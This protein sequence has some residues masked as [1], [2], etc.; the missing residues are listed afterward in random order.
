MPSPL[1]PPLLLAAL[2]A[3]ALPARA[4]RAV[5]A[6]TEER[7]RQAVAES[8]VA[9]GAAERADAGTLAVTDAHADPT[10]G[11]TFVYLAQTLGGV[12]VDA[13]RV[14]VGLGQDGAPFHVA[15][16]LVPDIASARPQMP[17]LSAA[18]AGVAAARA[19][20]PGTAAADGADLVYVVDGGG[21]LRLAWRVL[22]PE[23]V[24]AD[25]PHRWRVDVDAATGAEIARADL[26]LREGDPGLHGPV[27]AARPD[28]L[29]DVAPLAEQSPFAP[30]A[31]AASYRV[32]ALPTESPTHAGDPAT[33]LRTLV[34]DPHDA[35][36][37]LYGWHDTNGAVGAEH[38][39]TRGNNVDAA[40]HAGTGQTAPNGGPG[41]TFSFP[42]DP[43]L[44]PAANL[45]AAVTNAFY[46]LNV[47]HDVLYR[48][49][50][51]EGAGDFQQN[52]Y[53]RG[54][55]AGDAVGVTVQEP[56]AINNGYMATPVD[57]LP[58]TLLLGRW[59]YTAPERDIAF[60]ASVVV[61]EYAH[62]LSN[63]LVGGPSAFCL[64][65]LEQPGEGWSDLV[66]MLLTMRPGDNRHTPRGI[67]AYG[68]G[69]P[70]GG[71]IRPAPYAADFAINAYTYGDTRTL[72]GP[73]RVGF[74]WA[75]AVW[76]ATW[77][78]IDAYGFSPDVYD[79]AGTAGNQ[80]ALR[81]L[82]TGLKLTPCA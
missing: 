58:P 23:T 51:T 21:S 19:A 65:D 32:Y 59:T 34:A 3:F 60:D 15:G 36:A 22:L 74:V 5:T 57:G 80:I 56:A 14:V 4:Q 13:G 27:G 66:A 39:T 43:T 25:G 77:D 26:V 12:V 52:N 17:A 6:G 10:T 35:L 69:Q 45:N 20:A 8:A 62:G 38:T 42:F 11:L 63:R 61:H 2:L 70:P 79:A 53:G 68:T 50:F 44:E 49:G 24:G 81:L 82:V 28:A 47:A 71:T 37:S 75:T 72:L 54:G 40:P 64:G 76:E 18:E 48:Y 67:T 9:L 41:L 73:H 46:W 55:R 78:L 33:D 1:R 31:L 30:L 7:A 16:T 29:A